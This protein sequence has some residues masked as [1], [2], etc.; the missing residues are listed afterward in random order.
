MRLSPLIA[1]L[2]LALVPRAA[3]ADPLAELGVGIAPVVPDASTFLAIDEGYLRDAGFTPRIEKAN[4]AATLIPFLA[5]N[6]VQVVQ[7]GLSLG[8]FNAV[9]QG[10]PMIVALDSSSTPVNSTIIVRA[11][12]AAQF[13]TPRD[14]KGKRVA[15]VAPGSIPEY[16]VGKVLESDGL[17]LKDIDIKYI[18][19]QDM[20]AAFA[21]GAIDAALEVPPYTE[22]I[23]AKGLAKAWI[24]PDT[25]ITP[26][27]TITV[28]YMI[29]TDWAA[30][31]KDAAHR[32]MLAFAK[33]GREYCDAYHHGPNRG[34]VMDELVKNRIIEDRGLLDRMAWQS[35]DPNGKV[36][37][38]ALADEQ[39]L[40]FREGKLAKKSPESKLLDP[41]YAEEAAAKL[42]PF[43]PTNRASSLKG[44]R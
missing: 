7:G 39:D 26:S 11:D 18:P 8:Y 21:N 10:L 28:A 38:A 24:D 4:S 36:S 31:N 5:S 30:A 13:K 41:S 40:F 14:L 29:N 19:F 37:L 20:G 33:G 27:P 16:A 23:L 15:L 6:R 34:Q 9:A 25:V 32:V 1:V 17:T 3:S 42:G 2:V 35:R 12:I 43:T 44:C 22:P